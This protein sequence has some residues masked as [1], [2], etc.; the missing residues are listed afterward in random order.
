[1]AQWNKNNQDFLNNGRTLYEVQLQADQYGNIINPAATAKSAFGEPIS[2][3]VTPVLQLDGLY[4]LDPRQFETYTGTSLGL[5]GTAD[6]TDT[7]MQVTTGT[8]PYGYGVLRSKR[9]VRYRPGQG[10]QA[11][12]TAMFTATAGVG[13][14]GY[15]QRAGFFTQEQAL[16][17]GFNGEQFGVMR[18]NGGKA[19]IHVFTITA[20]ATVTGNIDLTLDGTTTSVAVTAGDTI[21]IVARKIAAAFAS[22]GAWLVE[23]SG[24]KVC[25]LAQRVG[26]KAGA[27]S[28]VDTG[29]TGVTAALTNPQVG[30]N[31]TE[32]WTYQTD[33]NIDTLDG[34][35]PSGVVLD[36]SKLNVFQIN[37]RW[38]GAGELRY[39][40]EN[41]LNGD[42]IFFHHE[43]YSNQ[44]VNVHIDNPSLKIGYVAY[45]IDGVGGTNVVVSG[46]SMMGA[47][48]GIIQT[49]KLPTAASISLDPNPN[50]SAIDY[51]HVLTLHNRLVYSGKINTR[52]VLLKNI[53]A[54]F[55]TS[56][57]GKPITV[58]MYYNFDALPALSYTTQ[59]DQYSSVYYST[60]EGIVVPGS[61]NLPIYIFDVP[62]NQSVTIDLSDLRIALPPNSNLSIVIRSGSGTAIDTYATSL[63]WVED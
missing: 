28:F 59:S 36:P 61:T 48:E 57:T 24:T 11:R 62:G 19:H 32:D 34:N 44:N 29:G 23:Y 33:F 10:A 39:A 30:V 22:S 17:I 8:D 26:P 43:H 50:L 3:P 31:H 38:L 46:A 14:A 13:V 21:A 55:T 18:Q 41:P 49:T 47:I 52:E 12:F 25:F 20:A 16:Q 56:P 4:G 27:F 37:F 1:M 5:S 9:A 51:H 58:Y 7:L 45:N 60:T 35:G 40:I 53:N 15:T 42:M 54:S 6:T 63:S 2:V